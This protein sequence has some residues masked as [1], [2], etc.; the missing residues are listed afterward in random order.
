MTALAISSALR[1]CNDTKGALGQRAAHKAPQELPPVLPIHN[2]V[3]LCHWA[4]PRRCKQA[5]NTQ[6]IKNLTRDVPGADNS[7]VAVSDL[8]CWHSN[9]ASSGS[10]IPIR[11]S[12]RKSLQENTA[13]CAGTS[14]WLISC[15]TK[16]S[17]PA[18]W[19][20]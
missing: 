9:S 14:A 10:A 8:S 3:R 1:H 17:Q 20:S 16:E 6:A 18:K 12:H 19:Q 13:P 5:G 15:A 11:N 7:S 4:V 2:E